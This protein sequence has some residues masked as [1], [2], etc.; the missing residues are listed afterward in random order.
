MKLNLFRKNKNQDG[1]AQYATN[2][3]LIRKITTN[4]TVFQKQSFLYRKESIYG[5]FSWAKNPNRYQDFRFLVLILAI[6]PW[7]SYYFWYD[8]PNSLSNLI[9][10]K[11]THETSE[12]IMYNQLK[13]V[14][15][16]PNIFIPIFWGLIVAMF[17][18]DIWIISLIV[19]FSVGQIIFTIA[20]FIANDNTN[21]ITPFMLALFGRFI[22]RLGGETL[23]VCQ[24]VIISKYFK[25]KELSFLIGE[26]YILTW[27]GAPMCN[28]IIPSISNMTSLGTA[29]AVA[30]ILCT[31]QWCAK[32]M[33]PCAKKMSPVQKKDPCA[34]KMSL[35][36]L[37]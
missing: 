37:L 36:N 35:D 23:S 6:V 2:S 25:N 22:F 21:D 19:I 33:T 10:D 13:T 34:K 18:I 3:V 11:L 8:L 5:S 26:F 30:D 27:L 4:S 12:R 20:G 28:Y 31:I 1:S 15:S 16:L 7:F 14:I 24:I 9:V 29:I 17:G 32:K